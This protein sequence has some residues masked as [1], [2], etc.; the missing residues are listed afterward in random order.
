MNCFLPKKEEQKKSKHKF[1]NENGF[2]YK[3]IIFDYDTQCSVN[4]MHIQSKIEK[5]NSVEY[6]YVPNL[7]IKKTNQQWKN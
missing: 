1:Y 2:E 7:N 5:D 6:V 3:F 4:D